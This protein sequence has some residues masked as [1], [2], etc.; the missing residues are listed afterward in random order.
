MAQ[1]LIFI[2]VM[3]ILLVTGF[4]AMDNYI[5]KANLSKIGEDVQ[6]LIQNVQLYKADT[7]G[8]FKGITT[9][10]LGM[11]SQVTLAAKTATYDGYTSPALKELVVGSTATT[12]VGDTDVVIA[13]TATD[14]VYAKISQAAGDT[15]TANIQVIY[16]GNDE[17]VK[18]KLEAKFKAGNEN[19][20]METIINGDDVTDGIFNI[21]VK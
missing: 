13:L 21:T 7:G 20:S 5:A 8:N 1:I 19:N 10:S 16:D 15:S 6:D 2:V 14:G 17:L 3:A 4:G 18:K 11:K 9:E 12:D